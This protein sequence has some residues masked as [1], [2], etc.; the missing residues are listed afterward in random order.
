[1]KNFYSPLWYL[2]WCTC[3][4]F[5]SISSKSQSFSHP[6]TGTILTGDVMHA[7]AGNEF[8]GVVYSRS[9]SVYYNQLNS[10]G[11]WGEEA[12]LGTGSAARL[13]IDKDG[14]PHVVYTTTATPTKIAY[15]KY[16]GS[17]WSEVEYIESLNNGGAG[18]CSK[19]DMAIAING[20]VH[21]TYTDSHGSTGDDYTHPD[22]MYAKKTTAIFNIQLIYRGYRDYSSSGSWGA[23]YFSKGSY[24]AVNESGDYFIIAHRQNIWRWYAGT[25][26]TYFIMIS[27][28]LGS[29]NISNYGSDIFTIHD[30]E[31]NGTSVLALYKQTTFK[32][33]ELTVSG[34]TISFSNTQEV[35]TVTSLSSVAGNNANLAVGGISSSNLFTQFNNLGHIYTDVVV[36][37]S[38]VSAVEV[39]AV[40]YTAY[41]DNGDSKI[42][43]REVAIPLSITR[44]ELPGQN[45]PTLIDGQAGTID[46]TFEGSP[47]L[48]SHVAVFTTT[49]D[50]T[51]VSTESVP[52]T[53]GVT[54][55]DFSNPITYALTDGV[56]IRNWLVN[57]QTQLLNTL[58]I[59]IC[60]GETYEFGTQFLSEP[61]EYTEV[62][63]SG[64]GT[65]SIVVLT[66]I[67]NPIYNNT[68]ME[69]ICQG[70]T[71]LFGT[72]NITSAGE[73]TE[74]FESKTG[75][76]STVV[77]TL[78]VDPVYNHSAE[79]AICQG[80]NYAFGTQSLTTAGEYTEVFESKTGCDSTVVLTLSIKP[81]YNHTDVTS[82]CQGDT[83]IFGTQS[84]TTAGEYTE[85]FES[86]TGCDS[87]V[88]LTLSVN[89]VYN[90]TAEVAICQGENYAFGT[91]TLTTEG[92]YTEVFES[93]TGC[94]STVVLSLIV[95]PVFNY[96][97]EA[98]I[99]Q[100]DT[101]I[102]GTQT[103]T[104]AGEYTE[105]FE[106]ETGCDSTVV[107]TLIVNPVYNHTVATGIC[108]GDTYIFGTQTLTTAGEYTEEFE[109]KTGCDSTV[110]L[111][112]TINPIYNHT[113]E[114]GICQGENYVFGTQTLTSDGEYSE[115]FES[116][117]GCDSTVVLTLTVNPIFSHTDEATICHGE[118]Y[119]FG[120]QTLTTAGEYTEVF[121]SK[122]SCDSTVVL[123]LTVNPIY[124]HTAEAAICQG[125]TYTLGTQILSETGIYTE[126]FESKTGCDSTVVLTLSVNP[127][128]NHTAEAAVC[129]DENYEFGTQI[130]T[131]AGEYTE[132]FESK[133]GCDSKI[134]RASCRERV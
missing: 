65:D 37:N 12:L 94:D 125:E 117:E 89:P 62:F 97:A 13:A 32:T 95:N 105:V 7:S 9:G 46:I 31:F 34:T 21:I 79:A 18:N 114:V 2:L 55:N 70:E 15:L 131:A 49:A 130:L 42:K 45:G 54:I 50:V 51:A 69:S 81:T 25:D 11:V 16:N 67:V 28:N 71:Y 82:I 26:N 121:E 92:E 90:H 83:Y 19:P 5:I 74:V 73:Y 77:L 40:F 14:H 96:I 3:F 59:S 61:G 122:T 118:N 24:I 109:S 53:S 39:D 48:S 116:K 124:N 108:Q 98:G 100:G 35:S 68:A 111:T 128:Y 99:C 101:Y 104:T 4:V 106:S 41:T 27:S 107:L 76:D 17:T 112:L 63:V 120:S 91:Q 6:T 75:C 133:T 58:E 84:L 127:E 86:K 113:A 22:I 43:I 88:V 23:D 80:E 119:V 33:S 72:Q 44:F 60:E 20:D 93:E 38:I 29:G 87:T 134:G 30:L 8:I 47:D 64:S 126:V 52:Q 1:M 129:Q 10:E 115:V 132:I 78:S 110:V 57:V 36:K 85:V 103:L 123:T 102:F 56:T 66:L